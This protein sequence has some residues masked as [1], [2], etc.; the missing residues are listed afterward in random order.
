MNN[1]YSI[2]ET[3]RLK[4]RVNDLVFV[5][6]LLFALLGVV[7]IALI[8]MII[9]SSYSSKSYID[10]I[11]SL[12]SELSTVTTNY[13]KL[14]YKYS[15]A[16]SDYDKLEAKLFDYKLNYNQLEDENE[17]LVEKYNELNDYVN[18]TIKELKTEVDSKKEYYND[19]LTKYS[20]VFKH[21]DG[22]KS[23]IS[24]EDIINL[25]SIAKQNNMSDDV[26][27]LTLSFAKVE[28]DATENIKNPRSTAA[29]LCQLLTTTAKYTY[30]NIMNNGVGSYKVSYSYDGM[31]NLTMAMYLLDYLGKQSNHRTMSV[32]L[33]YT[34]GYTQDYLN[35]LNSYLNKTG[36][37]LNTIYI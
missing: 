16:E 10:E 4:Q 9:Y 29:G 21:E 36:K 6:K 18:T 8:V 25:K 12:Q 24:A 26:V 22:T 13:T 11:S 5:V 15:K 3:S 19:I 17:Q 30:E 1:Y 34:G 32:I 31:T 14:D 33:G 27:D 2:N 23:D 28:S 7:T 37:S 20:F 35:K